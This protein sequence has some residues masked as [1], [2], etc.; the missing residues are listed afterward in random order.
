[1]GQCLDGHF[2]SRNVAFHQEIGS[3]SVGVA[4]DDCGQ[5]G[6]SLRQCLGVVD[7]HHP[8]GAVGPERLDDQGK[9]HF[10]GRIQWI[11][12]FGHQ[13]ET[14]AVQAAPGER[15]AHVVFIAGCQRSFGGVVRQVQIPRC[16]RGQQRAAVVHRQDGVQW[17]CPVQVSDQRR[18]G[19]DVG[20]RKSPSVGS[21]V[22]QLPRHV[23]GGRSVHPQT[24]GGIQ[25]WSEPIGT[26]CPQQQH[27]ADLAPALPP[28]CHVG[29]WTAAR[30]RRTERR[31]TPPWRSQV[32]AQTACGTWQP[33]ARP[34]PCN[35]PGR[36][37]SRSNPGGSPPPCSSRPA[38]RV[39]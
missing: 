1:M 7:A 16:G 25:E 28:G 11:H 26:R 29:C 6:H 27:V 17:A 18:A 36:D 39:S 13:Q 9:S 19:L 4:A 24:C 5:P 8:L 15:P 30:P 23:E 14:R 34:P 35:S 3:G 21:V 20:K 12:A 2:H 37:G 33:W 22:C 10:G 31:I 38:A 32:Y